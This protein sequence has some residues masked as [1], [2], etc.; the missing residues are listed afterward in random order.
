MKRRI[1]HNLERACSLTHWL[2]RR[3]FVRLL[4][5]CP[6]AVLSWRL[7]QRWHTNEWKANNE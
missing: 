6:L 7:D 2:H 3:P 5:V 4:P 1:V